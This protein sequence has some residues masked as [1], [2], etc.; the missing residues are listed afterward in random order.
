MPINEVSFIAFGDKHEPEFAPP[1]PEDPYNNGDEPISDWVER[2]KNLK[3]D[4][5]DEAYGLQFQI[6]GS[7][8]DYKIYLYKRFLNTS[9]EPVVIGEIFR[10][11]RS[12]PRDINNLLGFIADE[13]SRLLN[14]NVTMSSLFAVAKLVTLTFNGEV[15][16]T[17]PIKSSG[18]M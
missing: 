3:F 18:A 7:S 1:L 2:L 14:S 5:I 13:L 4:I 12:M 9:R 17:L 6:F 8:D 15:I 11:P 10:L 16:L